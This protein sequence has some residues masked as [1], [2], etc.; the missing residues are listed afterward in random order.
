MKKIPLLPTIV[1][2][3]VVLTI[4]GSLF[5]VGNPK[6]ERSYRLDEQRVAN[7]EALRFSIIEQYYTSHKVLPETLSQAT[8]VGQYSGD[9][10]TDPVTHIPYE[11]H[12]VIGTQQ[13]TLCAV[14]DLPT[15]LKRQTYPELNHAAGRTCFDFSYGVSNTKNVGQD[16]SIPA[17]PAPTPPVR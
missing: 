16:A 1:T 9:I 4:I 13:Y 11:Y 12:P 14:F 15:D 8:A 17:Q 2:A 7:L 6:T 3:I 5:L 10:F